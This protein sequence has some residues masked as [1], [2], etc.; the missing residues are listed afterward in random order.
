MA[1]QAGDSFTEKKS[2]TSDGERSRALS[3]SGRSTRSRRGASG[4]SKVQRNQS[5][6]SGKSAK[7]HTGQ[8]DEEGGDHER[9]VHTEAAYEKY[10]EAL[11]WAKEQV[12][13]NVLSAKEASVQCSEQ[14]GVAVSAEA[15]RLA[16]GAVIWPWMTIQNQTPNPQPNPKSMVAHSQTDIDM[17]IR[18]VT[19][20]PFL[21]RGTRQETHTSRIG[22]LPPINAR[23]NTVVGSR[24]GISMGGSVSM[25]P[26]TSYSTRPFTP[27]NFSQGSVHYM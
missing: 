1:A 20:N 3:S 12:L 21:R 15:V 18:S 4:R 6:V 7:N 10:N 24:S 22:G 8:G 17:F 13:K 25:R 19:L 27:G 14:W 2:A 26:S 11:A 16:T 23:P 9:Y 5:T